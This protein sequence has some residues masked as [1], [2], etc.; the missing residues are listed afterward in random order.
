MNYTKI[1]NSDSLSNE[2]NVNLNVFGSL[3]LHR[4]GYVDHTDIV[5]IYQC[6]ATKWGLKL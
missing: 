4:V 1:T 5:A 2:V 3:M 6:G